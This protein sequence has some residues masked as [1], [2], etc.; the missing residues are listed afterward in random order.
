VFVIDRRV[1]NRSAIC[2]L[3]LLGTSGTKVLIPSSPFTSLSEAVTKLVLCIELN[4]QSSSVQPCQLDQFQASDN[5][6]K[7]SFLTQDIPHFRPIE[8]WY[9]LV[10][11]KAP[12]PP[13]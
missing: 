10:R 4:D 1:G 8:H 5:L 3:S 9:R 12:D 2:Q 13:L 6:P 7:L 11:R